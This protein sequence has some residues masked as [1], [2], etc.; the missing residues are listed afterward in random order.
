MAVRTLRTASMASIDTR[1]TAWFEEVRHHE[2]K[3]M[4]PVTSRSWRNVTRVGENL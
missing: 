1:P 4:R 3:R 2:G